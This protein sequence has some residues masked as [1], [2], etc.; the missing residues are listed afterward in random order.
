MQSLI[1][2]WDNLCFLSTLVKKYY[3]GIVCFVINKIFLDNFMEY[4]YDEAKSALLEHIKELFEELEGEM[5]MSH[6]E[7][8]ALL[9]DILENATDTGELKVAFEQ[10]CAEHIAELDLDEDADDL[11]EQ[12]L[13]RLEE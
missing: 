13:A 7:K 6:Q 4:E 3:C 5:A 11:W 9:E 12:A 1:G 2:F 10:W 8:Y